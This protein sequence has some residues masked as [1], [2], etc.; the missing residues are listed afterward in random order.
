M[1]KSVKVLVTIIYK[2]FKM[3]QKHEFINPIYVGVY[4]KVYNIG[5]NKILIC[6]LYFQFKVYLY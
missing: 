3:V 4:I 5:L 2:L 1:I 6:N